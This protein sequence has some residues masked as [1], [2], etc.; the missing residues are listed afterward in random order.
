MSTENADLLIDFVE[1][2]Y[3]SV[4]PKMLIKEMDRELED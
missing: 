3:R 1:E 2:S 4:A